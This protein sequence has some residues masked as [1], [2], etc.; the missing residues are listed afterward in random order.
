LRI[1]RKERRSTFDFR[2]QPPLVSQNG[3]PSFT[4]WRE[5]RKVVAERLGHSTT[6]LTQDTYQ[7]VLPVMQERAAAKLD[8]IFRQNAKEQKSAS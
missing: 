2:S 6:R 1:G 4:S 5:D 7:H 8:A 3:G